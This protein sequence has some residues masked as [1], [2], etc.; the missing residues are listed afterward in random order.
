MREEYERLQVQLKENMKSSTP[1]DRIRKFFKGSKQ[2][3]K[4]IDFLH[5]VT[6]SL[7]FVGGLVKNIKICINNNIFTVPEEVKEGMKHGPGSLLSL[8]SVC[9]K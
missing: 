5:N 6:S 9:S 2:K 4:C 7:P 1:F 8:H 3:G